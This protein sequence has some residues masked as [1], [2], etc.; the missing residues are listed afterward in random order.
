MIRRLI[1]LIP[2]W[3]KILAKVALSRL[4]L[5]HAGW[6]RLGLFLPG[7]N[8]PEYAYGVVRSHLE[9][10]GWSDL[11]GKTV[12]ELGPGD[13]LFTALVARGLGAERVYLVDAGPCASMDAAKYVAGYDYLER[14]GLDLPPRTACTSREGLLT[15]CAAEYLTNGVEDLRMISSNSVDLIWSQAVLEHVELS[16]IEELLAEIHRLLAGNGVTSHEVDLRDHLANALNNLRFSERTWEGDLLSSSG[17]YT[18]RIRYSQMLAL[19]CKVG[20]SPD[21]LK[22]TTW[23]A[24]PTPRRSLHSSF[25]RLPEDDLLVST[26]KVVARRG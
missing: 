11:R 9:N 4:P 10:I 22:T 17:F 23:D 14:Q 15:A 25:R 13:N 5:S 16:E 8:T 21:V 2:W 19:F 1:P 20:L 12:L 7:P 26:F 18:N 24:M 6:R 3:G